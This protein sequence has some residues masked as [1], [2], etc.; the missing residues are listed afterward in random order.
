[1]HILRS[2]V[3]ML[4]FVSAGAAQEITVAAA[5]DLQGAFK[6]LL[7]KFEASSGVKVKC[8]FGSSGNIASQI[9]NGA[10]YD[11]FFSADVQYPLDLQKEGLT[12]ENSLYEYAVGRIVLWAPKEAKF[13]LRKGLKALLDPAVRKVAIANPQHAPY[14]RAAVAALKS[15]GVYD[16]VQTKFVLGENISQAAQFVQTGNADAG[17]IALS[18]AMTQVMRDS[19]T[20]SE[21]DPKTYPELRQAAVVLKSAKNKTGAMAFLKYIRSPEARGLLKRYGFVLP[22]E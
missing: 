18:L 9:R 7:P 2:I 8:S 17:I 13:D 20:Y 16:Q 5:S 22:G 12:E 6:E 11:M 4:L 21:I 10:P 1:M 15:A 3:A 19:G 14:G